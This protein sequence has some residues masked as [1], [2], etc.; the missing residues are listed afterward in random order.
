MFKRGTVVCDECGTVAVP[1]TA[2]PG[3]LPMELMMWGWGG[4]PGILYS[5]WRMTGRRRV[6]SVC[7]ALD[8]QRVRPARTRTVTRRPIF[9]WAR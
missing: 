6:C 9:P 8:V 4:T 7:G 2:T 1:R 3:S 5:L